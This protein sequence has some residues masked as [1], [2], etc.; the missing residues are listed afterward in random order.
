MTLACAERST[1]VRR[2][3]F[4]LLRW[5]CT[6]SDSGAAVCARSGLNPSLLAPLHLALDQIH[7]QILL[8]GTLPQSSGRQSRWTSTAEN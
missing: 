6:A 5:T 7:E 2:S 8:H 3:P 4:S 1:L